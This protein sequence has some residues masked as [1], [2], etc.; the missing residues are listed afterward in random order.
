MR[1]FVSVLVLVSF[2]LL[3]SC[4]KRSDFTVAYL[5]PSEDR[6]R[7]VNEGRFMGERFA[8]L[9]VNFIVRSAEDNDALQ[10]RQG[11]ELLDEG[12]DM[13]IIA[14]VNGNTIAPLVRDAQRRG[15]RVIAYNRLI[16]NSD[17]DLFITGNNQQIAQIFCDAALRLKPSGNY[18]VLGGDRFDRNGLELKQHIDSILAPH[19]E[20]GRIN[21]IYSTFVENWSGTRARFELQQILESHGTDIDAVIACS[22][23]MGVGAIELLSEY[24]LEG[25]VVVTG[26]DAILDAVRQIYNGNMTVTVYHPHRALGHRVADL[27]FEMLNGE[28][29]SRLANWQTFNG[30]VEI[31]TYRMNSVAITRQNIEEEL[32]NVGQYTWSQIRN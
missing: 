14:C 4:S 21:L 19:I 28:R 15:V 25:D 11:Y 17:Y 6:A 31:P 5:N 1:H 30:F 27:A 20:S 13:L 16:N 9:G 18:V 32:I 29:S 2:T 24:G 10:L 22:D 23:P 8:E 3:T 26:Q 7:F 12:V